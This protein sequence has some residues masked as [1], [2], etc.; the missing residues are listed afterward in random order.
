MN[1]MPLASSPLPWRR[2][3]L[4]IT[5]TL[6]LSACASTQVKV[7]AL[8]RPMAADAVSYR[9]KSKNPLIDEDSLRHREAVGFVKTALS[10]KG[11][12]EAPNAENADM[13]VEVDYGVGPPQ[14]RYETRVEPIYEMV[15]GRVYYERV[16]VGT[17]SR[18]NPIYQ[19]I[20]YQEPPSM[21]H[22]GDREYTVEVLMYEKYLRMSARENRPMEEGIPPSELWT[23]DVVSE[24]KSRDLRRNLPVLAA[25][26]M[27]YIGEE[28]DG[29]K[30]VRIKEKG[31]AVSFVKKGM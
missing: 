6:L 28:T 3:A 2:G 15:P 13:V 10:S 24:G 8:T 19:T 31:E 5:A 27:D 17:D 20:S 11:L 23:V 4:L 29:Q 16:Q 22:V 14:L 18:G 30:V 21:Q 9:I 25:A 26:G 1:A 12:Y 7:D